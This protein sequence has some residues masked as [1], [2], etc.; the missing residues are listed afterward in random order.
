M[1]KQLLKDKITDVVNSDNGSNAV[2]VDREQH[3]A[4]LGTER[5]HHRRCVVIDSSDEDEDVNKDSSGHT[6]EHAAVNDNPL[7]S[8][9]D[10]GDI[11][12]AED[13]VRQYVIVILVLNIVEFIQQCCRWEVAKI[14]RN[15]L[16]PILLRP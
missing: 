9:E 15:S 16:F 1:K 13:D 6:A 12:A 2:I 8:A 5:R 11:G 10:D 4:N 7:C 3:R 14:A